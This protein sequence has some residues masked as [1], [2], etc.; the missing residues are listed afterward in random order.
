MH[1]VESV[2]EIRMI[3]MA[4]A[5]RERTLPGTI[6][7]DTANPGNQWLAREHR[8]RLGEILSTRLERPLREC[9]ILDVGCG[10]GGLLGWFHERGV[11]AENLFGLDLLPNRINAARA[12]YP[13]FT[14]LHANAERFDFPDESFD[15]MAAFTV[16]SSILDFGMASNVAENMRRALKPDGAVA[17]YDMRYPNPFNGHLQAMT[18]RRIRKL[19]PSFAM[20]LESIS[21]PPPL[22][23]RLGKFT[24]Q[25]YPLLASA[26]PLRSHYIGLLRP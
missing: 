1:A 26:A 23:R 4:Y 17:W 2:E 20:E 8:E 12:T 15:L 3:E 14:L 11:P 6:K 25:T 19:F 9:R 18:P 24:D 22:A 7:R 10:Y 16:F 5:E 21:L 13:E